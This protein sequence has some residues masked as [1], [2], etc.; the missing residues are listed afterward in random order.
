[1]RAR[2]ALCQRGRRERRSQAERVLLQET[3]TRASGPGE[4]SPS[5]AGEAGASA[6]MSIQLRVLLEASTSEASALPRGEADSSGNAE[7]RVP[8]YS[9][10]QQRVLL[11]ATARARQALPERHRRERGCRAESA[12]KQTRERGDAEL[13]VQFWRLARARSAMPH[14]EAGASAGKPS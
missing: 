12:G 3:S 6:G 13:R 11:E 9:Y 10:I 7:L 5:A 14:R 2:Q 4:A 1:M 8:I